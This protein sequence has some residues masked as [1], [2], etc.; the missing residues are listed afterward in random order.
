MQIP[1][2]LKYPKLPR[3]HPKNEAGE[4]TRSFLYIYYWSLRYN[5]PFCL[6]YDAVSMGLNTSHP[7]R[8]S[9]GDVSQKEKEE[10]KIV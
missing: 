8:G 5:L 1:V 9:F 2:R 10:P 7:D 6:E 4:S 3:E